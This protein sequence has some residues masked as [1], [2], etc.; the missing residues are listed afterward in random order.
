M[1]VTHQCTAAY[2]SAC[3]SLCEEGVMKC[4]RERGTDR[5]GQRVRLT[6]SECDS[7]CSLSHEM[8]LVSLG[9]AKNISV[10]ACP[11]LPLSLTLQKHNPHRKSNQPDLFALGGTKRPTVLQLPPSTL[12]PLFLTLIFY[13]TNPIHREKRQNHTRHNHYTTKHVT[14]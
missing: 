11:P 5:H 10:P 9:R 3:D 2:E 12:Y 7:I 6:K 1:S 8:V 13:W 4:V 14:P